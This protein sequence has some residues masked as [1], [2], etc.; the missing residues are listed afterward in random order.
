M[1]AVLKV[2]CTIVVASLVAWLPPD[3]QAQAKPA[4]ATLRVVMPRLT[5]YTGLLVAR[6][7]GWFAEENLSVSWTPVQGATLAVEAV[8]GGSAEIGG[9]GILESMVARGNGLD[10]MFFAA[11]ARINNAPPDNSA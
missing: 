1:P 10:L 11:A 5:N 9:T 2:L 4:P 6:D 3:A 8:Y 7:K